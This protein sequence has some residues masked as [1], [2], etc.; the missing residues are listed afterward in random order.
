MNLSMNGIRYIG[1]VDTIH[2]D[3]PDLGQRG[4]Q[5]NR[6]HA[7]K[8]EARCAVGRSK[9][10]CEESSARAGV[11]CTCEDSQNRPTPIDPITETYRELTP[12]QYPRTREQQRYY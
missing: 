2:Q 12:R 10:V 8:Q 7:N 9:S 6:Q 5:R 4:P 1:S 11:R 3:T